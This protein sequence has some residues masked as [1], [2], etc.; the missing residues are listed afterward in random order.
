MLCLCWSAQGQCRKLD[1]SRGSAPSRPRLDPLEPALSND[2]AHKMHHQ[3]IS[4]SS[5]GDDHIDYY[6]PAANH[7]IDLVNGHIFDLIRDTSSTRFSILCFRSL[8]WHA[9]RE[10][11]RER[12]ISN[13]SNFQQIGAI[14]DLICP[15]L[16]L[17]HIKARPDEAA[18][19]EGSFFRGKPDTE[20]ATEI[21]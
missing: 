7:T 11:L 16:Q 9:Y 15:C 1:M 14:F 13:Q 2:D 18:G 21:R 10:F 4:T 19:K 5:N 12:S 6:P 20:V 8:K 3:S 17:V